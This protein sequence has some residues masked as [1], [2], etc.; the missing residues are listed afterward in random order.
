MLAQFAA[1]LRAR[2]AGDGDG[3]GELGEEVEGGM[4]VMMLDDNCEVS[5]YYLGTG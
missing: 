2:N 4:G 3:N 5:D 1:R